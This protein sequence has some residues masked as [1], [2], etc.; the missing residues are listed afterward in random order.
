M[1]ADAPLFDPALAARMLA[2]FFRYRAEYYFADGYPVGVAPE[3]VHPR[4]LPALSALA[5][6]KDEA[7]G[8]E[9]LFSVLQRDINSF[10]L[11]TEISRLDLREYRLSL[12]CD[13]R[14]NRIVCERLIDLG[15]RDA[16]SIL[17]LVPA[18]QAALR[19]LP[20]YVSVQVAGAVPRP[21]PTARTRASAGTS[22][23]GATSCPSNG[24]PASW[25]RPRTSAE[26]P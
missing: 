22:W 25:R 6:A 21:A 17:D 19:T 9:G 23:L 2:D 3:I 26:T 8:E 16:E 13:T 5:E 12:T 10:D 14:R 15:A 18:H 4:I 1:R 20:A 11:E 24:T 7:L